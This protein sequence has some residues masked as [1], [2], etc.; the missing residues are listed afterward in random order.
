M[1][2]TGKSAVVTGAGLGIGK[3]MAE[4]LLLNG[5]K[6]A[7]LDVNKTALQSLKESLKKEHGPE[8]TLFLECD[9][10]SEQQLTAA[11]QKAADT[12][13]GVDILVNNAGVLDEAAWEKTISI[14][15]VG[16]IRGT[17]V[18]LEHMN[19]LSGGRGGV[20]INTASMAGLVPLLFCPVYTATKHA[21]IGFTRSIAAAAELS[22]YGIRFNAICP[23]FVQTD[24]FS[25]IP[26][27]IGQYSHLSGQYHQMVA[28]RGV[29]NPSEVAEGLLKLLTDETKNGEALLVIP[30]KQEYV[31]FPEFLPITE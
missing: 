24:L 20:I 4:I 12:F 23:G 10:E 13:G 18:A 14:N 30:H 25:N 27:R 19:K 8:K 16:V 21:V 28:L 15:I 2:L 7:I 6:V 3:A 22:G 29:I 9:V 26:V 5:A 11:F 1:S 31:A 17:Y